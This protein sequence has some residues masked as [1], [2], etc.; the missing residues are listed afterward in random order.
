M[1]RFEQAEQQPES[2]TGEM[3]YKYEMLELYG[4]KNPS[5]YMGLSSMAIEMY[6]TYADICRDRG[7]K[8]LG[9]PGPEYEI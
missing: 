8:T 2:I 6:E 1:E 9:D 5:P 4:I 7:I 3:V